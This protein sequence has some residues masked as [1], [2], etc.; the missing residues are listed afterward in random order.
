MFPYWLFYVAVS[1]ISMLGFFSSK[2]LSK[3]VEWFKWSF[4]FLL[5]SFFVGFR[6]E[7]GG[8]WGNYLS[9]YST[10]ASLNFFEVASYSDPGYQLLSW[11]SSRLG[12]DIYFV[13]FLCASFLA[14]GIISFSRT[15][16]LPWLSVYISIPYLIV[17]VAM[18]YTRQAAAL[19]FFLIGLSF[20]RYSGFKK[21]IFW[22]V[23]GALF[24]KS[25]VLMLPFTVF[26]MP[27]LLFR[28]WVG[29]G[30]VCVIA[31]LL[32]VMNSFGGLWELYVENNMDSE[33][34]MLRVSMNALPAV[35]LLIFRKRILRD[36]ENKLWVFF[37]I[38]SLSMVPLVPFVSTA[39]D[40]VSLYFI[41]IQLFFFSRIHTIFYG[42]EIKAILILCVAFYY[43]LVMFVWLNF[44]AHASDWIPYKSI[45]FS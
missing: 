23:L 41:P 8:D 45:L 4:V 21:Y 31:V 29:V 18:G 30:A 10:V 13:N 39:I 19:G 12:G 15:Q 37:A 5:I 16:P 6:Y 42:T 44:A 3:G 40:R 24:H 34:A 2:K 36:N 7:V 14:F 11:F 28:Y 1:L 33:G 43:A 20:L 22:V 38:C 26:G 27:R 32:L 35:L 25:A 9:M 17:V